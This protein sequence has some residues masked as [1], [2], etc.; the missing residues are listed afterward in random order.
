VK[1]D[2]KPFG[3]Q[4]VQLLI[5][6]RQLLALRHQPLFPR[7]ACFNLKCKVPGMPVSCG[8]NMASVWPGFGWT[9]PAMPKARQG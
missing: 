8:K 6:F 4:I 3:R 9:K 5:Q 7:K 2:G 1:P